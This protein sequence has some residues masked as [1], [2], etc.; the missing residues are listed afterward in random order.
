MHLTSEL[1]GHVWEAL[2]CPNANHVVQKCIST[3]RPEAAQFIIEELI[4][5]GPGGAAQAAR[6]RF[7]C[8]IIERLLEHCSAEQMSPLV[9]ALLADVVALSSHMY[10]NFVVQ[11]LLEHC[12]SDVVARI[13]SALVKHMTTFAADGYAGS[14]MGKALRQSATPENLPLVKALLKDPERLTVMACSRW[15]HLAVKQA[16]QLADAPMRR[17]AGTELKR[18]LGRY[19]SSRYGRLVANFINEQQSSAICV[20]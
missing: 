3:I 12:D 14:V 5:H 10:G 18:R 15:G 16:M 19:R 4:H 11:H 7:G 1:M 17:Q 6:H 2:K 9:E 8:R 20:N 13:V